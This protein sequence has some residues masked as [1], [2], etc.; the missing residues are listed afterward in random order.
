MHPDKKVGMALGILL[1]G[2]VAAFFFRNDTDAQE[3]DEPRRLSSADELDDRIRQGDQVPYFPERDPSVEL[4]D[5]PEINIAELIEEMPDLREGESGEPHVI[6]EPIRIGEPGPAHE[7]I[8][9]IP[10]P[11]SDTAGLEEAIGRVACEDGAPA[12][13][14]SAPMPRQVAPKV[15]EVVSGET[16]SGLASKYL[17]THRRYHEL[18]EANRDILKSP[19]ALRVGMKLKIPQR[20]PGPVPAPPGSSNSSVSGSRRSLDPPTTPDL[21][22]PASTPKPKFVRPKGIVPRISAN[23]SHSVGQKPPPGVPNVE[24]LDGSVLAR[25]RNLLKKQASRKKPEK[26]ALAEEETGTMGGAR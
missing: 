11:G 8:T 7:R 12:R 6:P 4:E 5:V 23:P 9:P 17:G 14:S 2:I 19:D 25:R 21:D 15:H 26:S 24:G 3:E 10:D 20:N 16:L 1:V 13:E 22:K 18:F